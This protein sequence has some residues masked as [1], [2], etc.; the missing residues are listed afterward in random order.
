DVI[1]AQITVAA[2]DAAQVAASVLDLGYTV[3]QRIAGDHIPPGQSSDSDNW[4]KLV[5]DDPVA[6]RRTNVHVRVTGKPNQ[7]Y[8]I[9]FRDYLRANPSARETYRLIKVAMARL[10]SEDK[11]A[12]YDVKDPVCD[13]II[14]SA[15]LWTRNVGWSQ[16][17]SDA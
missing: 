12:Y 7:R 5:L 4:S 14:D 8:P 11:D 10:H 13:L 9:L 3:N 16:G 1:D 6:Q 15:E 17:V 2:L